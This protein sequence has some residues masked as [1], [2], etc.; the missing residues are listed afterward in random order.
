MRKE[1]AM[2]DSTE[3]PICD[4]CRRVPLSYLALDVDEPLVGWEAY[5]EERY[6]TVMDDSIGRRSVSRHVLGDLTAEKRE[7]EARLAEEAA[8]KAAALRQ[9]VDFSSLLGAAAGWTAR[10][11]AMGAGFITRTPPPLGMRVFYL[12]WKCAILS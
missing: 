3:A 11:A 2:D 5:F 1:N 6:I 4:T 9:P 8:E 12:N 7:R 10:L